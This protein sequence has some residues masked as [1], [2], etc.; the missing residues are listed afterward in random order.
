MADCERTSPAAADDRDAGIVSRRL[1][2]PFLRSFVRSFVRF[3]FSLLRFV[4]L[5]PSSTSVRSRARKNKTKRKNTKSKIARSPVG[6]QGPRSRAAGDEGSRPARA[7]PRSRALHARPRSRRRRRRRRRRRETRRRTRSRARTRTRTRPRS[8]RQRQYRREERRTFS[9][10]PRPRPRPRVSFSIPFVGLFGKDWYRDAYEMK[11]FIISH[12]PI[13][14]SAFRF[15]F[16]SRQSFRG[17]RSQLRKRRLRRR[18]ARSRPPPRA[19]FPSRP[20]A[21]VRTVLEFVFQ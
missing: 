17:R 15:R 1:Q 5:F 18:E 21:R 9:S 4:S 8:S 7:L 14:Y 12:R 20:S 3:L 11:C 19:P 13:L 6:N 10:R 16:V 2:C